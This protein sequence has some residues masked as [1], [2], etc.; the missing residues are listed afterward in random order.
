MN[1]QKYCKCWFIALQYRWEQRRSGFQLIWELPNQCRA[2][3]P[4][5]L[6]CDET[7]K[8]YCESYVNTSSQ[9]KGV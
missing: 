1:F 3:P 4:P 2:K 8:A 9:A 7:E 6:Q 5:I